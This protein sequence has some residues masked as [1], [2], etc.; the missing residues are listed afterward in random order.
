MI[1]IKLHFFFIIF[2]IKEH[3]KSITIIIDKTPNVRDSASLMLGDISIPN[4]RDIALLLSFLHIFWLNL[5]F[6]C[7]NP[8]SKKINIGGCLKRQVN[9]T[10]ITLIRHD[11]PD[12]IFKI[13]ILKIRENL[14]NQ[15]HQSSNPLLRQPPIKLKLT[16]IKLKLFGKSNL[17]DC[18]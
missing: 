14:L 3:C 1:L 6:L 17:A 4:V 18:S 13:R 11:K 16:A 10:L 15:C 7:E 5:I 8:V 9:R 12:N 2:H